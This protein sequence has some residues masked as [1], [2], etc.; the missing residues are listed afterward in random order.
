M[1]DADPSGRIGG[2]LGSRVRGGITL[3]GCN[4]HNI[5]ATRCSCRWFTAVAVEA[6]FVALA[7]AA[8]VFAHACGPVVGV[9]MVFIVQGKP[10][11]PEGIVK[12]T[13][14]CA[15]L[16]RNERAGHGVNHLEGT[17]AVITCWR[18]SCPC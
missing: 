10:R 5:G 8:C 6:P 3:S 7:A 12:V 2:P 14:H 17:I 13:R 9:G 15:V 11:E 1:L 4:E 16:M 18:V